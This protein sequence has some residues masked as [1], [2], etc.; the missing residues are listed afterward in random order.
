MQPTNPESIEVLMASETA[1]LIV[2]LAGIAGTLLSSGMGLYFVARA[3]RSPMR[4]LLYGRQLDLIV[5][6]L[7]T[8]GRIRVFMAILASDDDTFKEQARD[9]VGRS[10]KRLSQ[11][12]DDAAALLPT[13]L[14]VEVRTLSEATVD[15]LVKIDAPEPASLDQLDTQAAKTALMTRSLL[16]VDELSDESI[17]LFGKRDSLDRLS[18]IGLQQFRPRRVRGHLPTEVRK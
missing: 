8:A 11:L 17:A 13:E 18:K 15:I 9:D 5:R 6:I 10:V 12:S 3:R 1:T 2:G 7:R 14:F 16:G 4:E